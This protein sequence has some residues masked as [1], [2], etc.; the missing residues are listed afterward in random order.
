MHPSI[1]NQTASS[2][3]S[4]T[5]SWSVIG[6]SQSKP[7]CYVVYG[8]GGSPGSASNP[9]GTTDQIGIFAY[10]PSGSAGSYTCPLPT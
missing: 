4:K 8:V 5:L 7:V 1:Q 2:T 3:K 6:T 9:I 10:E